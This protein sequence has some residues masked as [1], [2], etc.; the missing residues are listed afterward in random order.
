[1]VTWTVAR[2]LSC[3][4]V[5]IESTP[6][7][8][9]VPASQPAKSFRSVSV[10][11]YRA[12]DI[13]PLHSLTVQAMHFRIIVWAAKRSSWEKEMEIAIDSI[14]LQFECASLL[15][16]SGII[17]ITKCFGKWVIDS[18]ILIMRSP[19]SMHIK[20]AIKS[21]ITFFLGI[22]ISFISALW[23]SE[24]LELSRFFVFW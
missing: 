7:S 16:L 17:S 8:M 9:Q 21:K 24:C 19:F 5:R 11:R 18:S 2:L 3:K 6:R 23:S 15:L 13:P 4:V 1:M 20:F 22:R 12:E 14:R 10:D